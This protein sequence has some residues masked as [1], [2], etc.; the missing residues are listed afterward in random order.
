MSAKRRVKRLEAKT[1]KTGA[2]VD[3]TALLARV[4]AKLDAVAAGASLPAADWRGVDAATVAHR[5]ALL[6]RLT[7]V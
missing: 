2:T 5:D 3:R 6:A 4:M 1:A 7:H